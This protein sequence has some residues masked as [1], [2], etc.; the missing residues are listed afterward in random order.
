MLLSW[1]D[2]ND[3]HHLPRFV[4]PDE[5]ALG[6][7]MS[8]KFFSKNKTDTPS[9][10]IFTEN[11]LSGGTIKKIKSE[12]PMEKINGKFDFTAQLVI[13]GHNLLQLLADFSFVTQTIFANFEGMNELDKW[14]EEHAAP[15]I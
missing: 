9:V 8:V 1:L 15:I 6:M 14:P 11:F 7:N 4:E 12:F 10:E 5:T 2:I 13:E 3:K